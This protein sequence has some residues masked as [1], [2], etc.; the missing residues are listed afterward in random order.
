MIKKLAEGDSIVESCVVSEGGGPSFLD[1]GL[2]EEA[3]E[4]LRDLD[5]T[6]AGELGCPQQFSFAANVVGCIREGVEVV[7]SARDGEMIKGVPQLALVS[8]VV[9][10]KAR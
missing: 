2:E 5:D 10:Q 3:A 7:G 9:T 4:A 6:L 8:A 1:N